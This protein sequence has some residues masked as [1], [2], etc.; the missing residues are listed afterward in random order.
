MCTYVV[1]SRRV[2]P[3]SADVHIS[4]NGSILST[5]PQRGMLNVRISKVCQYPFIIQRQRYIIEKFGLSVQYH[6]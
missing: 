1:L 2:M 5:R 6:S 4:G 3:R